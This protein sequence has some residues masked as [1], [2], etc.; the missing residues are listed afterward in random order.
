MSTFFKII[1][2]FVY[3]LISAHV[4]AFNIRNFGNDLFSVKN[5]LAARAFVYSLRQRVTQEVLEENNVVSQ[6]EKIQSVDVISNMGLS[7]THAN[8]YNHNM[9]IIHILTQDVIYI[10]VFALL[11]CK[12]LKKY[13]TDDK[14]NNI[15]DESFICNNSDSINNN[16]NALFPSK[17]KQFDIYYNANRTARMFLLIFYII[18][19]KNIESVT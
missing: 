17:L 2:C 12:I 11:S 3:L 7:G 14:S 10:L 4:N 6:L 9:Q 5:V 16:N 8:F 19:T 15:L 1:K 13:E 18:F